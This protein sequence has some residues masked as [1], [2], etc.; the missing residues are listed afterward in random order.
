[1][2]ELNC[3]MIPIDLIQVKILSKT[4][5]NGTRLSNCW[6]KLCYCPNVRAKFYSIFK[7]WYQM[8]T[9]ISLLVLFVFATKYYRQKMQFH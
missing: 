1:M 2:M 8:F 4:L 5:K 3:I 6:T 7:R 9:P